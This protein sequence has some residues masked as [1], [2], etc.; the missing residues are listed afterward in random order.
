MKLAGGPDADQITHLATEL[1][2]FLNTMKKPEK[3]EE[4]VRLIAMTFKLQ[5][6]K[7]CINAYSS[8]EINANSSV[9]GSGL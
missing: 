9:R 5:H 8:Q 6:L 7:Q 1:D 3:R 4:E 2:E